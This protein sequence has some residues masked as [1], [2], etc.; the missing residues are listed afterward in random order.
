MKN[1][2]DSNKI[3][4]VKFNTFN[5]TTF[6]SNQLQTN[7]I[8]QQTYLLIKF[9]LALHCVPCINLFSNKDRLPYRLRG[10]G[11]YFE[12]RVVE[13]PTRYIYRRVGKPLSTI[14]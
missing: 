6:N 8:L 5:L 9:S 10:S 4:S 12:V 13:F 11:G 14:G 1:T 3:R 7:Y 2:K